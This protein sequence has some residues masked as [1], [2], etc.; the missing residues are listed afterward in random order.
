M[1]PG[2]TAAGSHTARFG[3]IEAR[4]I[5]L[6]PKGRALYD[7]L[8]TRAR[9]QIRPA[10]DGSNAAEYVA[11]MERVFAE[12]PDDWDTIRGQGLGYF[13]W[14]LTDA[15]A[16]TGAGTGDVAGDDAQ[17]LLEAGLLRCDPIIYEDFLPVSAAGIFQS[18]LGDGAVQD[19]VA[20]PNQRLFE[21]DLGQP[22][23]DEFAHYAQ[24][25]ADSLAAALAALNREM[26]PA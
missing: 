23:L 22:V 17:Q 20:S 16:A 5:A 8:L 4:G 24:I 6:T 14:S 19:F 25:E 11:V 15:G 12:F 18:N 9:A 7:R 1:F 2:S 26:A 10:A 3:E 13:E 21:A